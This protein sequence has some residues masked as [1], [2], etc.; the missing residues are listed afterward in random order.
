MAS[1]R[2]KDTSFKCSYFKMQHT[3]QWAKLSGDQITGGCVFQSLVLQGEPQDY[4]TKVIIYH[5]QFFSLLSNN[6]HSMKV[7]KLDA[8]AVHPANRRLHHLLRWRRH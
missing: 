1:T 8:D 6:Q 2:N 3:S 4:G 7:R 5:N